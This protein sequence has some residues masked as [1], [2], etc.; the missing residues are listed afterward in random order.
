MILQLYEMIYIFSSKNLSMI[1]KKIKVSNNSSIKRLFMF[2][3]F[4]LKKSSF[5]TILYKYKH[6]LKYQTGTP[7]K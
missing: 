4:I 1:R 5:H 2:N 7:F 6:V 3:H